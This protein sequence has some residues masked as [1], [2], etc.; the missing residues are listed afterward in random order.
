MVTQRCIRCTKLVSQFLLMDMESGCL[1][2]LLL[3]TVYAPHSVTSVRHRS[4]HPPDSLSRASSAFRIQPEPWNHACEIRH[5]SPI[6]S[7]LSL[8]PIQQE[9]HHHLGAL[10]A[11][12]PSAP[13]SSPA[14][15]LIIQV[16]A[17]RQLFFP[18]T[19]SSIPLFK[20]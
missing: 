19:V 17:Q 4:N 13:R 18:L 11:P 6:I 16:S 10:S 14:S 5:K 7:P 3:S 1:R 2:L 8:C 20:A 15:F 9:D 12:G